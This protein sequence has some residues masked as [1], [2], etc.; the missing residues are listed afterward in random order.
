MKDLN[1][2][3]CKKSVLNNGF[4]HDKELA[5]YCNSCH[6]V[7]FPTTKDVEEKNRVVLQNTTTHHHVKRELF[8]I[9]IGQGQNKCP[10]ETFTG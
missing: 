4:Y 8:P 10:T 3:T 9:R 6:G 5:M 2:P 1:C 7:I